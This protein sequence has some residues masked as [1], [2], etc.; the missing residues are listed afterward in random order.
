VREIE[1]ELRLAAGL[2]ALREEAGMLQR[3]LAERIGVSQP[4]IAAIERSR[5]V[6]IDVLEQYVEALGAHLEVTVVRGRHRTSLLG[7]QSAG[8]PARPRQSSQT[9]SPAKPT[10]SPSDRRKSA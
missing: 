3:E 7:P 1:D 10:R 4:R 5:N 9:A 2:T 6:T 8:K